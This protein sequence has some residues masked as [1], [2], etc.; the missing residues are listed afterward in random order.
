MIVTAHS[1]KLESSTSPAEKPSTGRFVK[2]AGTA[3]FGQSVAQTG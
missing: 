2:S 3:L 1:N